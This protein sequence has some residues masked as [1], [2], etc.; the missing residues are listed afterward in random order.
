MRVQCSNCGAIRGLT[1]TASNVNKT[2]HAGWRS[3]GSA[4]YCPK[5]V[6]TWGERNNKEIGSIDNT[7]TVIDNIHERNKRRKGR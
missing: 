2:I 3:Y 5:C 1:Y 4:L 7:I 6:E